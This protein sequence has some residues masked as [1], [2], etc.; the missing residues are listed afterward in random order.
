MH[1]Q[2]TVVRGLYDPARA[3]LVDTVGRIGVGHAETVSGELEASGIR[4]TLSDETLH[5]L[6][7]DE[8]IDGV[9]TAWHL[10]AGADGSPAPDVEVGPVGQADQGELAEGSGSAVGGD[11]GDAQLAIGSTNGDEAEG[12]E[13]AK[14]GDSAASTAPFRAAKAEEPVLTLLE[15]RIGALREHRSELGHLIDTSE[16]ADVSGVES[17]LAQLRDVPAGTPVKGA[18]DLADEWRDLQTEIAGVELGTSDEERVAIAELAKAEDAV[19][20]A[21][22][23]LRQPQ[24]SA[25]QI[26]KVEAAHAAYI[27]ASDR[28]ERRFGGGR[29]RKQLQEAEAEE[30]RVLTRYGFDSWVDY[31][32]STAKR[33]ADPEMKHERAALEAAEMEVEACSAD[34]DAVPGAVSRRRRRV[35]LRQRLD[36][37]SDRVAAVLGHQPVGDDVEEELRALTVAVDRSREMN[38]L[39]AALGFVGVDVDGPMRDL[40]RVQRLAETVLAETASAEARGHE[41]TG[42]VAAIDAQLVE[43][44]AARDEGETEPPDSLG[45]LPD[46]A[47]P[48]V[49]LL[50]LI[51]PEPDGNLGPVE[52]SAAGGDHSTDSPPIEL[53]WGERESGRSQRHAPEP[54][55]VEADDRPFDR[56]DLLEKVAAA[57]ASGAH[58]LQSA[59]A[60]EDTTGP[61]V[62]AAGPS[63]AAQGASAAGDVGSDDD[64]FVALD[65]DDRA[66]LV[67]D[68]VWEVLQLMAS[69]R[70][71]GPA[72]QLP[73]VF[74]DP[75]T[76]LDPTELVDLLTRLARFADL[77]QLVIVS[78]RPEIATWG[79]ALG[80]DHAVVVG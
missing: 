52:R 15:R 10:G 2:I 38:A 49:G 26:K 19:A 34:L 27:E 5:L 4:F 37:L 9:I 28:V 77:A 12:G 54:D 67:D 63:P 32:L 73:I 72:G 33:A 8:V 39:I 53:D 75:F 59:P 31:M 57:R 29:A 40:G 70:S 20:Q 35:V 1:P 36:E 66:G 3:W 56:D 71:D 61:I 60:A 13:S 16:V 68:I 62:G 69:A 23:A 18:A 43:L 50:D 25:E 65:L 76:L 41:L 24:L 7:L 30:M 11:G 21:Q 55:G 17:A 22:S 79:A 74:D 6:G 80:A 48:P 45:E 44:E 42:A 78:D 58:S 51:W 46:L 64:R 14:S 47:E